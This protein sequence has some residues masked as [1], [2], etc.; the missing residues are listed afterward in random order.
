MICILWHWKPPAC[1]RK[2]GFIFGNPKRKCHG[3]SEEA[4]TWASN[5]TMIPN[6]LYLKFHQG[7]ILQWPSQSPD[8]NPIE[9]L[10][11][12]L[13]K[14]VAAHKLEANALMRNGQRFLRNAARK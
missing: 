4:E 3:V 9:N 5:R 1:G 10:W 2:G 7:L 12:D 8:L 14:G 11:W 6:I 13:K